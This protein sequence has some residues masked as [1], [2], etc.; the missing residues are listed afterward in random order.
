M[1]FAIPGTPPTVTSVSPVIQANNLLGGDT[2]TITGSLFASGAT[3]SVGGTACT[4]DTFVTATSITCIAPAKPAGSYAV[5]V[6]NPD[7]GFSAATTAVVSYAS[8]PAEQ[9]CCY[10]ETMFGE[11]S[12]HETIFGDFSHW[13][14]TRATGRPGKGP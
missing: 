1:P 6:T 13:G 7:T 12:Y 5:V 2:L 8:G 11:L 3:V 4:A 14:V 9:Y 10:H